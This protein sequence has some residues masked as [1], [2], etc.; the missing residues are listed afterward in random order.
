MRRGQGKYGRCGEPCQHLP[1]ELWS[2]DTV[3][4]HRA[5]DE[6]KVTLWHKIEEV[7]LLNG[8]VL[9]QIMRIERIKEGRREPQ[10]KGERGRLKPIPES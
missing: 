7:K 3:H 2:R 9:W 1:T 8:G 6:I 5:N 4:N 10:G